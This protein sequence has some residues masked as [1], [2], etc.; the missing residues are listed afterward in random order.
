MLGGH[1]IARIGL[2]SIIA[3]SIRG[4]RRRDIDL[5]VGPIG[6]SRGHS[7]LGVGIIRIGIH[8]IGVAIGIACHGFDS[9]SRSNR[10]CFVLTRNNYDFLN[11]GTSY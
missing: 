4:I 1:I 7:I 3:C 9:S 10:D 8:A 6:V 5:G 2:W 11:T